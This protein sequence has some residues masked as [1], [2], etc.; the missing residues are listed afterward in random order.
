MK[1]FTFIF[2]LLLGSLSFAAQPINGV[3]DF[4][5]EDVFLLTNSSCKSYRLNS[6]SSDA[7]KTIKKLAT[8]D[9]I[10]GMGVISEAECKIELQSISYVGLKKFIGSW[11][12]DEGMYSIKDFAT[13]IFYPIS[14][15]SDPD[16]TNLEIIQYK[17]SLTP[18]SGK[19]WV[20][21]LS[22]KTTTVFATLIINGDSA[23]IS[24]YDS[25]NGEITKTIHL[26][27]MRNLKN[28]VASPYR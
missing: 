3:L 4:K 9:S 8:G 26:T 6:I 7:L 10:T 12:G 15:I 28:E 13:L 27:K 20:L 23:Q 2:S 16:L 14:S 18:S 25:E 5:Y 19:E 24:T 21:F 11:Y 17:Y 1:S 22:D